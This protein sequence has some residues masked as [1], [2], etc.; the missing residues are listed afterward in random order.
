MKKGLLRRYATPPVGKPPPA[1]SRQV[2]KV[3]S[4]NKSSQTGPEIVL[5]KLLRKRILKADLPGHPD[6]VYPAAKVAVFVHGCFWHRCPVCSLP[7]PKTH[8]IYWKRKFQRNVERDGLNRRELESIGWKV[9][10]VWEHEVKR[11]PVAV[12][13]KIKAVAVPL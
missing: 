9:I 10:E 11:D 7:L 13:R 8:R 1:R 12:A 6:F 5:S 4:S 3:M 2:S